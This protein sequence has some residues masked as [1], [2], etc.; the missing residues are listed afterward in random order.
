[1]LSVVHVCTDFW[2]STGGIQQVVRGLAAR[3]VSAGLRVTVLCFN[4]V[5][6]VAGKL[7]AN[8]RVDDVVIRRIPFLDLKYYKPVLLP[9]SL[10]RSHDLVHVHGIGAPLDY[11]ALTKGMHQR[12][13][14]LSTHG[15]IFHTTALSG[16]KQF[17]F[18]R[19]VPLTLRRI[20][21]IAACSASDASVF[22][23]IARNVELLENAVDVEPFLALPVNAK[24]IGRFLY[25]GRLADNKGITQLLQA[26]AVARR[27]GGRFCLRLVG[28]DVEQKTAVYRA[29]AASL[30]LF[31][32]VEFV[33]EVDQR[34]LLSEFAQAETF[35]SAS[36]YEGFGLSAIEAKA[37]G[38]RL[39]LQSNGAFEALFRSSATAILVDFRDSEAAGRAMFA[40]MESESD[41]TR[42][43]VRG[44]TA[45][46]S[47]E[48]KMDQWISVYRRLADGAVGRIDKSAP[49][50]S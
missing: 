45:C 17:Y 32:S 40:M 25:V 5:K 50:R 36:Q 21:L 1:L 48:R 9:L 33:G 10:L 18:R 37:A 6:G 46:Y 30:G 24:R 20:E 27:L 23:A 35:V 11:A 42:T 8:D 19:I 31:D 15:G 4:K 29:L 47:W 28:P 39:L 7:A 26:A 41:A 2:P 34:A 43:S 16:L 14:V 13:I 38:C 49:G 3:S 22:S 12:P 44:E